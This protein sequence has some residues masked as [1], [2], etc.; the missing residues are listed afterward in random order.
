MCERILGLVKGWGGGQEFLSPR[1]VGLVRISPMEHNKI[2]LK[3]QQHLCGNC[4][5]AI[6]SVWSIS[7][8]LGGFA[9]VLLS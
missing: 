2:Y 6:M 9:E 7:T 8:D 4:T 3:L 1:S 5:I